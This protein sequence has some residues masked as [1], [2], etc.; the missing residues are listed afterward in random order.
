MKKQFLLLLLSGIAVTAGAAGEFKTDFKETN[1]PEIKN[2]RRA[3][4][5]DGVLKFG[6]S[7]SFEL[8]VSA[9]TPVKIALRLRI[10]QVMESKNNPYLSISLNGKEGG[11]N[12]LMLRS[13]GVAISY[14]YKNDARDTKSGFIKKFPFAENE[15]L[16]VEYVV[17]KDNA[18]LTVNGEKIAQGACLD[19]FPL[20]NL[21][22]GA[23][24][25]TGEIA[26]I[27]I[28]EASPANST[29]N[30]DKK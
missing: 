6:N 27:D 1:I 17:N 30:E 2:L 3:E 14:F 24:N 16:N 12:L 29:R 9:E 7:G 22:F 21:S 23:Y 4:I 8:N 28:S 13:D 18:I 25:L 5:K 20:N 15:F 26:S 11:K 19:L 10:T